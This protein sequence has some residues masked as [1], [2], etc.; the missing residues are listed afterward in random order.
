MKPITAAL[1]VANWLFR[2]S[3]LIYLVLFYFEKIIVVNFQSFNDVLYFIY[4][5]S[6]LLLFVGGFLSK[7]TLSIIAGILVSLCT[8]YFMFT[9]LPSDFTKHQ[10][11]N[12]MVY[13]L[14]PLSIGL[15][16]AG[17]DN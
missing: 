3:L 11:L 15:Y 14:W 5:L 7:P 8:L 6:G 1:K 4:V 13:Y 16:F 9:H 12:W 2:G 17:S 10:I